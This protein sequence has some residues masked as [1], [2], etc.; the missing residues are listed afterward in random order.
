M[1]IHEVFTFTEATEKWGI[2]DGSVLRHAVR[3]GKFSEDEVRQSGKVWLITKQAMEGEYGKMPNFKKLQ[4]AQEKENGLNGFGII[5]DV[6]LSKTATPTYNIMMAEME[7]TF[8]TWDV[9]EDKL[10]PLTE[11]D[12]RSNLNQIAQ[13]EEKYVY[14]IIQL[15]DIPDLSN[16]HIEESEYVRSVRANLPEEYR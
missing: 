13:Q 2:S 15:N 3:N 4:F 6:Y 7:E 1:S 8:G 5:N 12:I 9:E 10:Q 14:F 16:Y 11:E